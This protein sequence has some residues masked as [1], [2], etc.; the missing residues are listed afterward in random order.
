MN[1]PI[2]ALI[3]AGRW[4]KNLLAEFSHIAHVQA[5]VTRN[6]PVHL[7]DVLQD[8]QIQAVVI[9][10][11]IAS[12]FDIAKQALQAGKHVFLEKPGTDSEK[13]LSELYNLANKNNLIL[14]V[15]YVFL[16]HPAFEELDRI[17][18]SDAIVEL[19]TTWRKTG[20]FTEPIGLSLLCHDLSIALRLF[21]M[22]TQIETIASTP[23]ISDC[24]IISVNARW[25]TASA[26]ISIDRAAP[27][28][29]KAIRARTA[30]GRWLVWESAKLHELDRTSQTFIEIPLEQS[31]ALQ[32]ECAA[33]ITQIQSGN[34]S[35]DPI[36]LLV[37]ACLAKLS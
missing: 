22:P 36:A 2:I 35:P 13:L 37:H 9:A 10:T 19:Q 23:V 4:G 32:R 29:Y 6:S 3:G 16:H 25:A 1:K 18:R 14:S 5:V 15:G 20:T 31:T 17:H 30:S 34:T 33:F 7:D 21:G 26:T 24:D 11:P 27:E 12:H 28:K 8:P